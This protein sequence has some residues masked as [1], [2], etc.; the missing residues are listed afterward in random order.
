MTLKWKFDVAEFGQ[1]LNV[2]IMIRLLSRP[3]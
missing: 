3:A 1:S 2:R